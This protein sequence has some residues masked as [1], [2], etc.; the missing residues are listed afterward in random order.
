[1]NRHKL[2]VKR[3]ALGQMSTNNIVTDALNAMSEI[4]GV[5]EARIEAENNEQVE[6]SYGYTLNDKFWDT[7]THLAKY[8][9]VRVNWNQRPAS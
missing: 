1:M 8:N 4:P 5:I 2:V 6:I 7:V 3:N 9:L